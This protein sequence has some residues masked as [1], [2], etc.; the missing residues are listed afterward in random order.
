MLLEDPVAL[1]A[2]RHGGSV[3]GGG[4]RIGAP[5]FPFRPASRVVGKLPSP[6]PRHQRSP[7][8]QACHLGGRAGAALPKGRQLG[9][10]RAHLHRDTTGTNR[11]NLV[12]LRL[13]F[14]D[15]VTCTAVR[16]APV[17]AQEAA[18]TSQL[19]DSRPRCLASEEAH[20]GRPAPPARP[21]PTARRRTFRLGT[22]SQAM[23]P[24]EGMSE[25]SRDSTGAAWPAAGCQS[26]PSRPPPSCCQAASLLLSASPLC[27]PA[28]AYRASGCTCRVRGRGREG[29]RERG[30]QGECARRWTQA[31]AS[32]IA[33]K[34]IGAKT[35]KIERASAAFT[36]RVL[37]LCPGM[38]LLSTTS[39]PGPIAQYCRSIE[40]RPAS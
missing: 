29:L 32:P 36:W 30:G 26:P 38:A 37:A 28:I 21:H 35:G 4:Q 14:R 9:A 15:G 13:P 5:A 34:T 10:S 2:A 31:Q 40:R 19:R 33:L 1:A 3:V 18:T 11:M 24:R 23:S 20:Q 8:R 12:A 6:A 22:A 17:G 16:A 7:C 27:T 25:V 39:G